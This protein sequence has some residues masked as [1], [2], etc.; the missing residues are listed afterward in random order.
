M[1]E[2]QQE[3]IQ[4]LD[5]A[6]NTKLMHE[7]EKYHALEQKA[8]QMQEDYEHKLVEA[9]Q[10]KQ[11]A[12]AELA[13]YVYNLIFSNAAKLCGIGCVFTSLTLPSLSLGRLAD[14]GSIGCWKRVPFWSIR[15]ARNNLRRRRQRR[16]SGR[17]RR[18]QTRSFWL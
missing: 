12:L 14:P 5:E 10:E 15:W 2:R 11:V 8:Q 17:S 6:H 13:E 1:M 7:Y 3:E 4:Q 16:C 18:I 9:E